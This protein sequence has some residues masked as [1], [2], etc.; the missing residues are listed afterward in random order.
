VHFRQQKESSMRTLF[1]T[2]IV[3]A[4]VSATTAGAAIDSARTQT[5]FFDAAFTRIR[6][7]GPPANKVGHLQMA[8]GVLRDA[9]GHPVGRFAFTC[10]WIAM[11][12][13]DDAREHC[14][15]WGQSAEGRLRVAGPSRRSDPTHTWT[16]SGGSG[17]YRAGRGTV[18]ARD[19]GNSESL[20]MVTIKPRAGVVLHTGLVS[21]PA[22]NHAFR[23][24]ADALCAAAAARLAAL[25]SFPLSNF[26][27]LHP[28]PKLL[29][30]VGRFFTGPHDPRPILRAL[31]THLR[32]LGRPPIDR[33]AWT[34]VLAARTAS[35]AT[36]EEQDRAALADDVPAFVKSVHDVDRASRRVARTATIFGVPPCVL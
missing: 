1:L 26:D 36:N 35:L 21:R 31:N 15:G 5:L 14:S 16:I 3:V 12:A 4:S 28:D 20:L 33:I 10:R 19:L 8:S 25:P 7:A 24:R 29:P 27:P 17:S 34:N 23:G 18:V 2:V 13:N 11:L 9:R 6:A 32:A 22:A 30:K